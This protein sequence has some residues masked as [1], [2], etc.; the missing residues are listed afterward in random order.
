MVT[1]SGTTRKFPTRPLTAADLPGALA[2]SQAVRWPHR[3]EDWQFVLPLGAGLAV[4][5]RG[6]LVGT[7]LYWPLGPDFATLG[8]V[9][10]SPDRQGAGIG[11][12]LMDGL[13]DGIGDRTALLNATEAGM[14]LY[15][16][17]GFRAIGRIHQHQGDGFTAPSGPPRAGDRVRPLGPGDEAAVAALDARATG[18]P[19]GHVIAA[20]REVADGVVLERD[21]TVAGF[22]LCRR[23]GRG[24]VAGPVV[25]PDAE[26]AQALI[27]HWMAVHRGR[28]LRIDMVEAAGLSG[29]LAGQ[30][31]PPI[32]HAI[33]MA[34]GKAPEPAGTPRLFTII[35]QAIG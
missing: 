27:G 7:G 6:V 12:R 28:F 16:K 26:G 3:L 8:L 30:G 15:E 13:L 34:R 23:F 11:R 19:R 4:E 10:V 32:A 5:D 17:L 33:T 21:G 22:A 2:L 1:A 20:L 25:A 31:L 35:N 14:P 29:W 18:L 9:I 24:H